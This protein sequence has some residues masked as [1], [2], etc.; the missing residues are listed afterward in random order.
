MDHC[1]ELLPPYLRFVRGVVDSSDLP[2]NISRELLQHN[3]LLEKIRNNITRSIFKELES[4]KTSRFEDYVKF[5]K[6]LGGVLKEGI[7]RDWAHR[8]QLADLLLFESINNEP[9]K[10]ITLAQYVE[11]M[12]A[13]QKEIIYLA[14][15]SRELLEHSPYLEAYRASGQDVLLFTEPIDEFVLPSLEE[16]D[17]KKLK[18][19][20]R[21]DQEDKTEKNTEQEKFQPLFDKLK[22]KLSEVGD[23][24]LST[25]LKESAA[26]LVADEGAVE[27]PHGTAAAAHGPG[28]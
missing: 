6:E 15:E 17:G 19:A 1:E 28:G 12:P 11:K 20:D 23:I 3:P 5:F 22:S 13:E 7:G 14:G 25:R 18:A 26:C 24:R 10:Y 21:G 8:K 16:F 4:M 27:R 2:L 9:G